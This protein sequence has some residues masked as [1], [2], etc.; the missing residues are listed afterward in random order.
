MILNWHSSA[1]YRRL[2]EGKAMPFLRLDKPKPTESEKQIEELRQQLQGK[3]EQIKTL[4]TKIAKLEPLAEFLDKE[5]PEN[6]KL[7]V[8]AWLET[9]DFNKEYEAK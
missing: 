5:N 6:L 9:E 7:F 8:K 1:F 4:E 2:Y 3:T